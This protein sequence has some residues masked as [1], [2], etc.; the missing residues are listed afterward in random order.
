MGVCTLLILKLTFLISLPYQFLWKVLVL[1][2]VYSRWTQ[3]VACCLCAYARDNGKSN[4]FFKNVDIKDIVMGGVGSVI[5]FFLLIGLKGFLL[6][7]LGLI[8]VLMFIKFSQ[9]KIGGM[10]GDSVGATNEIAEL[11]I[12]FLSLIFLK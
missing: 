12:L 5:I 8:P 10:T 7:S 3:G 6:F 1:V 2:V 9:R 11:T 4:Y